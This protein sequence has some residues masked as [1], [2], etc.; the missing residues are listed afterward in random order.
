[1]AHALALAAEL[2][3]RA[4]PAAGSHESAA[5]LHELVTLAPRPTT[6]SLTVVRGMTQYRLGVVARRAALPPHHLACVLGVP[7]TSAARTVVDLARERQERIEQAGWDVVRMT[8]H[9]VTRQPEATAARI[10]DTLCRSQQR[11]R[12]R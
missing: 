5:W 6:T 3:T 4:E 2:G 11:R 8:W 9:Q 1:V 12:S 10:R 7:V